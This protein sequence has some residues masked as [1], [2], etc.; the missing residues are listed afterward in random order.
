MNASAA[1]SPAAVA[2]SSEIHEFT[3]SS[4]SEPDLR[5]RLH[6]FALTRFY[7]RENLLC[8]NALAAIQL[9]QA[10]RDQRFRPCEIVILRLELATASATASSREENRPAAT[11]VRSQSSCSFGSSI[12]IYAHYDNRR[13]CFQRAEANVP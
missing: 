2:M 12:C 1:A 5:H 10:L 11:C 9:S 6:L 3:H 7:A 8:W 13:A 4:R